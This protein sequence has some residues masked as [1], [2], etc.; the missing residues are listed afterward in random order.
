MGLLEID[1][2]LARQD[3]G[4]IAKRSGIAKTSLYAL[5][6]GKA[7]PRLHTLQKI[8]AAVDLTTS[9]LIKELEHDAR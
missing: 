7:Q 5:R 8:A 4:E 3:L 2:W 9:A 6:A 1:R